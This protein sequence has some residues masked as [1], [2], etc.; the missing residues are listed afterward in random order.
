MSTESIEQYT[1]SFSSDNSDESDVEQDNQ[2]SSM[3]YN[4]QKR[5]QQG[6]AEKQVRKRQHNQSERSNPTVSKEVKS[7]LSAK[8]CRARKKL[9]YQYLEELID[10]SENLVFKLREELKEVSTSIF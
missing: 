3:T 8:E 1:D 4:T 2:S 9:R 7:R 10:A 6:K 5:V